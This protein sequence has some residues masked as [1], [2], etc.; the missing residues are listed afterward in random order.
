M[1]LLTEALLLPFAP[2]RGSLWVIRQVI[3]EAERQYYDPATV[4]AELA[5]L[6]RR[7]EEGEITEEE[8]DRE[9]DALLDRLEIGL[10]HT[11]GTGEETTG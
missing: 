1:G 6:E 8:F 2:A 7:L 9:E 4:R 10:G 11:S 3:A 5:L